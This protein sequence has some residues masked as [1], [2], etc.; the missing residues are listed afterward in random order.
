VIGSDGDLLKRADR[1]LSLGAG[2]VATL[3]RT[4][5]RRPDGRTLVVRPGGMGDLILAQM[6]SERLGVERDSIVWLIERRSLAWALH[7]G[8]TT[9]VYDDGLAAT[10][11][12]VASRYDRV[13]STEQH[14][15]LA[16]AVAKL[17]T[18]RRGT[19]AAFSTNR[20]ANLA[21]V[22]VF[23]DWDHAHEVGEFAALL[24]AGL[25]I[26][27]D[28]Q[29]M[30]APQPRRRP[31]SEEVVV[32]LGGTHAVSRS[33]SPADW[34]SWIRPIVGDAP[35]R[36]TAGPLEQE[37]ARGVL[38]ELNGRG[39]LFTGSFSDVVELIAS[40]EHLLA[41]DGG[42]VHIA[43]YYGVRSD[44]LFTAGRADKWAPLAAGSR[45]HRRTDLSCQPCTVFGQ[46]PPCPF[47]YCCKKDIPSS[48]VA[49]PASEPRGPS[50]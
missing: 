30:T 45:V 26:L 34:V 29:A 18:R 42:P 6:A 23:Y 38:R 5:R 31:S 2:A 46:V 36:L 32:A 27:V 25:G 20:C 49:L 19:L 10:V 14:F 37:L 11:R 1:R 12:N 22:Q 48:L 7:Q 39:S 40:A 50:S 15:G 9:I 16:T 35:L 28:D 44:V 33:L 3:T 21:D 47:A 13:I 17:A 41:V 4:R 43:S 8:L 24:G